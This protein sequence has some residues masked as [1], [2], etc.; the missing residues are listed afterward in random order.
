MLAAGDAVVKRIVRA[1]VRNDSLGEASFNVFYYEK[2]QSFTK[3]GRR[4]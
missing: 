2:F 3:V 1:P 4:V